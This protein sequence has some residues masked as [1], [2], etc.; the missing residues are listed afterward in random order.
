MGE[1]R[2]FETAE[3]AIRAAQTGHLVFSTLHTNDSVSAVTRLLEMR[4]ESYLISSSL[5]CSISQRL[6]ARICRHCVQEDRE[7]PQ[8]TREEMAAALGLPPDQV[9]D[10]EALY[11]EGDGQFA[12]TQ[13]LLLFQNAT[14]MPYAVAATAWGHVLGCKTFSQRTFDALRAFRLTY[15]NQGP[16]QLGTGPE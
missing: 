12:P 3:I 2:D 16:E 7:I 13:Y 14:N 11:H 15:T 6:A 8:D 1:I 10:L 4:I 5:V 9:K